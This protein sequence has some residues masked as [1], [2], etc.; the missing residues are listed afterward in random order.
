MESRNIRNIIDTLNNIT[1]VPQSKP[2]V[3]TEDWK[4]ALN[5][6]RNTIADKLAVK[7][8]SKDD[9]KSY[10]Q[11]QEETAKEN[12]E[13]KMAKRAQIIYDKFINDFESA[14]IRPTIANTIKWLSKNP[15]INNPEVLSHAFKSIGLD[16]SPLVNKIAEPE[17]KEEPV[18]NNKP[19]Q[20]KDVPKETPIEK[21]ETTK[22]RLNRLM[23]QVEQSGTD[24]ENVSDYKSY[25]G[26]LISDNPELSDIQVI[27]KA[28]KHTGTIIKKTPVEKPIEVS[29][30]EEIKKVDKK[31]DKLKDN[32]LIIKDSND[33]QV[34]PGNIVKVQYRV[35]NQYPIK[36]FI[37]HGRVLGLYTSP[38]GNIIRVELKGDDVGRKEDVIYDIY[39]MEMIAN[40]KRLI[41]TDTATDDTNESYDQSF[42]NY[43]VETKYRSLDILDEDFYP[44][45]ENFISILLMED[46]NIEKIELDQHELLGLFEIL[47]YITV[48]VKNGFSPSDVAPKFSS[49]DTAK[50]VLKRV[51]KKMIDGMKE[52]KHKDI[53]DLKR[54]FSALSER[55]WNQ[56]P[57]NIQ[58]QVRQIIVVMLK[59]NHNYPLAISFLS[60]L[61]TLL[62]DNHNMKL[63]GL[64]VGRLHDLVMDMPMK[65][66]EPEVEPD[67]PDYDPGEEE[68]VFDEPDQYG[69]VEPKL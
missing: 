6:I 14:S 57:G 37:T 8:V 9:T 1:K 4:S 25:L 40:P 59:Q 60:V 68:Q 34:L 33:I 55:V 35:P 16:V 54:K 29:K 61:S 53:E 21:K 17:K 66:K 43:L 15:S 45:V 20:D 50:S 27:L 65:P 3:L 62:A 46:D 39:Q 24:I 52:F 47:L 18:K 64:F 38:R 19:K 23:S 48:A 31:D 28:N 69:R 5:N 11:D 42:K 56:L 22:E 67:E 10:T 26:T 49:D 32:S 30:T 7:S 13:D 63:I 51:Y 36:Q 2:E 41:V 58:E 44:L 12:I